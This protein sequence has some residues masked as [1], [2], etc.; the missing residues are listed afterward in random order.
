[1][2]PLILSLALLCAPVMA[3][4]DTPNPKIGDIVSNHILPR[5]EMLADT[6]AGLASVAQQECAPTSEG[7]RDAYG[8][9]F[10]AWVSASHLRFGPTETDDRAFALAFWPDS[11][12]ATPKVLSSLIS[13][14]DPIAETA[15]GYAQ[16]SIAGRGFYAMEFLLYDDALMKAGPPAYHCQLLQTMSADMAATSQ[17]ILTDWQDRFADE[18]LNPSAEGQYRSDEEVLQE[19][20]KSLS[21]GLQFTSETRLGRPLGTFEHPRPTRAE[22]RRSARSSLHVTL[23]L[24]SLRDLAARLAE[25]DDDLMAH[26]QSRFKK[27]LEELN[28]LDDPVFSSVGAPQTRLKV[29]VIQQ[30]VDAIRD[31]VRDGLGPTLG[32]AA[33]FNALD[34]D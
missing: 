10:D 11:R 18:M 13:A 2:R 24:L 12:G 14:Q 9:A 31:L 3:V 26:L 17:N 22:A 6:T 5:F 8:S 1:M 23:S 27:P 16:V 20:F 4:A 34:G 15:E 33:G 21:A 32:V 29:E 7:L 30:S 28:E 19:L 25:G